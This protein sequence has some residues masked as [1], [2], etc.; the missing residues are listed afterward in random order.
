[1]LA[2]APGPHV[3][4]YHSRQIVMLGRDDWGRWLDSTVP[5]GEVLLPAPAGTLEVTQI[6]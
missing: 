6:R 5:A 3:A 2:T 1:M 4:R